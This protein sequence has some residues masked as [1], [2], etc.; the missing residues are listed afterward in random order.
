MKNNVN[1]RAVFRIRWA[2]ACCPL[3][4]VSV[5]IPSCVRNRRNP[6]KMMNKAPTPLTP[7]TAEIAQRDVRYAG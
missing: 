3:L 2:A 4:Q 7:A 5:T 6:N 1:Q